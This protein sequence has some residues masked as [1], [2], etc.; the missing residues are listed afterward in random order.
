MDLPEVNPPSAAE[1]E[2]KEP[3]GHAFRS[4][5]ELVEY[6]SGKALE[7][8]TAEDSGIVAEPLPFPF[9]AIVG[10]KEMKL[11]LLLSLI[12]P[13]VGGV[14]LIGPRGTAKTT[15]VRS[16]LDLLPQVERSL[17]FYGCLP[18]DIEAGGIDAVCPDCARK[19]AEGRPLTMPD[20]VRLV[21]LP[22]NATLEDVIGGIDEQ[23]AAHER[24]R[25]RRGILAQ[26]DRNLLYIDEVNLLNDDIV[27]AILDAAA[28]G[29]YTVRRGPVS[30][31]YR[32]RF[33]LVG[34]MNPEE[35]RLRPQIMDRFGLRVIVRGLEDQAERLEAY[36]RVHAYLTNPR[37]MVRQYAAEG[38]LVQQEIE[39][40]RL[41]L[42]QTS[43]PD[44]LAKT[45]ISLV[46]KM[47]IDSL[48]A[49][50]TW[51]EAARA[52][53]A[54][55]GRAEVSAEDLK[56]VAPMA[57]RLRR[58]EFMQSYFANQQNEEEELRGLLN[59]W[60]QRKP[61]QNAKKT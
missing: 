28:Q 21:E 15:A 12:N 35:G 32:S 37:Q 59:H 18:E 34:S 24:R 46:Q 23:A 50:I 10:Q 33:V 44:K 39:S 53:A 58:S 49:E 38:A 56:A 26:A 3:V 7:P 48:R 8:S 1:S 55:D 9:L 40:A 6:V 42:S 61:R 22:L 47:G 11:A 36:R 30:G 41:R 5:K 43:I 4:L 13:A 31:S 52:H 25:I 29:S 2:P 27:D 60:S 57:L 54:A 17:C 20:R 14:L 16:L 45:A 51:F 19:Y